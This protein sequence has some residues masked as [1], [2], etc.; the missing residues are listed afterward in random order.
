MPKLTAKCLC[1][2]QILNCSN[3]DQWKTTGDI[4]ISIEKYKFAQEFKINSLKNNNTTD[5]D[6]TLQAYLFKVDSK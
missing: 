3:S 1:I 5:C 6:I 2:L 4:Q